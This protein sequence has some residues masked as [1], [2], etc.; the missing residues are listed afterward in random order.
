MEDYSSPSDSPDLQDSQNLPS[1]RLSLG[2]VFVI[3]QKEEGRSVRLPLTVQE[4][5][6]AERVL[7]KLR[8]LCRN[9]TQSLDGGPRKAPGHVPAVLWGSSLL[10][11]SLSLSLM[12]VPCL[13]KTPCMVLVSMTERLT[14]HGTTGHFAFKTQITKQQASLVPQCCVL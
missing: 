6:G 1:H 4:G 11:F 8:K 7:R 10:V 3:Q 14:P 9:K 5:T 13:W 12:K 2:R